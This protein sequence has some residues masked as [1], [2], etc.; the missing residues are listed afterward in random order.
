[1]SRGGCDGAAVR[2]LSGRP[3]DAGEQR[4]I[5][6]W[7]RRSRSGSSVVGWIAN[8]VTAVDRG[9]GGGELDPGLV[10]EG[11]KSVM[12]ATREL[13]CDGEFRAAT[14]GLVG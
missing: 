7:S 14:A 4:H 1:M 6:N 5:G 11:P 2:S 8:T 12:A 10:T 9:S 3:A 13:A